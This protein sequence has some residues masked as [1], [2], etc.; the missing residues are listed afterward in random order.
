M[1]IPHAG[2]FR[3]ATPSDPQF[4]WKLA[5]VIDAI[6]KQSAITEQQGNLN[7]KGQPNTP[8]NVQS[9]TA[10]GANGT[11]H[12]SIE[13]QSA[14]L[15]KGVNYYVE[16]SA[17]ADF[18]DSQVR[19]IGDSRSADFPIGNATRYVRAY[20]AYP[21]SPPSAH[22]YHGS[23]VAPIAVNGG[24]SVGPP[25]WL[26]SQGSGTGAPGQFG[27]GPGI[28]PRRTAESGVLFTGRAAGGPSG[29]LSTGIPV[30]PSGNGLAPSG[31][32]GGGSSPSI[33]ETVIAPCEALSS[34]AGTNTI[35]AVTATPYSTLAV[36]FVV[37]L[38][39]AN[40]NSGATTLNVNSI[41]A[42]AVTKNGTTALA[43]G[44]LQAG[45][46]YVLL[47]DGTRFQI[48]GL[49]ASMVSG[50]L[51]IAAT[52]VGTLAT[53]NPDVG[54]FGDSTHTVTVTVNAKGLITSITVNA[55]TFPAP[56]MAQIISAL[57]YTPAESGVTATGTISGTADLITG[58][59]TG[60]CSVTQV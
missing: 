35:V 28:L 6:N 47:Y 25:A 30:A 1:E 46:A 10:T 33:S 58:A 13:D 55:I 9:V 34:V 14:D 48:V 12:V 44:E 24:G 16:H 43:G 53:V 15:N 32:G 8:P 7:P 5:D 26:P 4:S 40:T 17:F 45:E 22:V 18:R 41:G 49:M 27:V 39:P 2:Y 42:K 57:G 29:P 51:T 38:I 37:R 23:P 11:L 20:S 54:S 21:S 60:T 36:G 50:D 19:N 52:G 56:T 3:N 59:V 31:G